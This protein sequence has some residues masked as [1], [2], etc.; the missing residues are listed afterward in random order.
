[1]SIKTKF[2]V[3]EKYTTIYLISLIIFKKSALCNGTNC[4]GF[5]V[6]HIFEQLPLKAKCQ[7]VARTLVE[8][9]NLS[10]KILVGDD[11]CMAAEVAL[12]LQTV[13]YHFPNFKCDHS[14][15]TWNHKTLWA[16]HGTITSAKMFS[17]YTFM[18]GIWRQVDLWPADQMFI[19]LIS[20]HSG[21]KKIFKKMSLPPRL[22]YLN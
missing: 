17:Y 12:A 16:E 8:L 10:L 1:M 13:I 19:D 20:H 18:L 3:S 5:R 21:I 2:E 11:I 7:Q 4:I 6:F 9:V 22:T 15:V 14:F